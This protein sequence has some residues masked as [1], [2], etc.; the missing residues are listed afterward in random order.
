MPMTKPA[1]D[2]AH[3]HYDQFLQELKS[4]I[5]IP[6][7]STS[8]E[9][10]PDMRI[11]AE[12]L[13]ARLLKIGMTTAQIFETLGHPVVY[14]EKNCGKAN[15]RTVLIYGHYDVQPPDP[16]DLWQSHPF[17]ADQRD[18]QL[19]ARGASDMKGQVIASLSAV[20][21][22][23]ARDNLPVNIKFIIE[24]EEEI[25]SPNLPGFIEEHADL[26][27]CDVV[28]NPDAGMVSPEIPAIIYALRGLSYFELRVFGPS[29]DL[30]SGVFGGVVHNPAIVL[31]E[32][33]A[34]MHD[35]AGKIT[36]PGF[37]DK[38]RTLDKEESLELARLP[39]K[40]DY[41]L[42]QTG[43]PALYGEVGY[44]DIERIGARPTLDVNG[45]L[46]GFTGVGSK[47]VI[48]AWAMA[49]ISMRLVPDQNPD[50]VHEQ[51]R[52]YL[53][54]KM[55]PTVTWE[56]KCLGGG[57]ASISDRFHPAVLALS[58]ALETIWG[59]K[60]VF[61]RE[62]G[63]VPI[64]GDFQKI[65]NVE[66]VLT[67]FGLPSDAIHSPNEHLHLPTWKKGIDALITF[68]YKYAEK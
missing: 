40:S 8:T 42:K 6:S 46:S 12:W 26:L 64:T 43:V 34:G 63:S 54:N 47:T 61:K 59:T 36:L 33:I 27:K 24:G 68:F 22:I 58:D 17:A 32:A 56:L 2:Y 41:Y 44:T 14:A 35:S 65:L 19:Y 51:L 25:G 37:Y 10:R 60:P 67:G 20:E 16:L 50:E 23:I 49:K 7:V 66:S 28:L 11:A 9:N 21:S 18:D 38:V 52:E 15:C 4:L 13:K 48:P 1:L 29:H 3:S 53:E 45:M 57:A 31:A 30:H 5:S 39:I 62:G 55:P